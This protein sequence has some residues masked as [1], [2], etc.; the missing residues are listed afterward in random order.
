MKNGPDFDATA[1][2]DKP[3]HAAILGFDSSSHMAIRSLDTRVQGGGVVPDAT[4][5]SGSRASFGRFTK[6]LGPLAAWGIEMDA[7]GCISV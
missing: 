3:P 1:W 6:V 4:G 7:Y 2:P 5:V